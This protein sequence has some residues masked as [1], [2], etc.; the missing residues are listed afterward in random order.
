MK[1]VRNIQ[2][3]FFPPFVISIPI[4]RVELNIYKLNNL[5]T[6]DFIRNFKNCLMELSDE[7]L[8]YYNMLIAESRLEQSYYTVSIKHY[9]KPH[10]LTT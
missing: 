7:E 10:Q 3:A 4:S 2:D 1:K 8:I 6:I 9:T 5:L